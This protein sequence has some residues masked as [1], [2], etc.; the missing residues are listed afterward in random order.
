MKCKRFVSFC[1]EW[2][3]R[4]FAGWLA[5]CNGLSSLAHVSHTSYSDRTPRS[6]IMPF[7]F[8]LPSRCEDIVADDGKVRSQ[9]FLASPQQPL[10]QAPFL[11]VIDSGDAAAQQV[12]SIVLALLIVVSK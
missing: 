7:S 3:Y 10:D 12:A 2:S 6:P 11:R 1:F 4:F 9:L 5:S 8:L